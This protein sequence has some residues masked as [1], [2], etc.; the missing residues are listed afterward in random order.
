LRGTDFEI[1]V[2]GRPRAHDSFFRGFSR[3]RRLGLLAPQRTDGAGAINL[4]MAHVTA[5]YDDYRAD[6]G[7]F[8]VYPDFFAFQHEKPL[9][10]YAMFDIWPDHK[11][12]CVDPQPTETLRAV[13]D[14]A[15]NILLLPDGKPTEHEINDVALASARRNIDQCYVYAPG[16]HA[17]DADVTIRC[18]RSPF[19]EWVTHMFD[20]L[21]PDSA[22]QQ[23]KTEWLA[24][25]DGQKVLEQSFRR[26]NLDEALTLL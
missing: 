22:A 20:S 2:D 11:L 15:V 5:F 26:V 17:R 21:E 7:E 24:G 3:N 4:V 16:G 14:R 6:G 13:T 9:A 8:F 18:N 19:D 23:R 25:C 1:I 10:R 12:V